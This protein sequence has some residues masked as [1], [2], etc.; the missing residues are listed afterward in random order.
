MCH[1]PLNGRWVVTRTEEL[2][3]HV[4]VLWW[5]GFCEGWEV[6]HS[7]IQNLTIVAIFILAT[8]FGNKDH[9]I[10]ENQSGFGYSGLFW[11]KAT[12]L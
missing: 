2:A 5:T 3:E 6:G 1:F 8:S 7:W 9:K 10:V 11:P 12:N 4:W